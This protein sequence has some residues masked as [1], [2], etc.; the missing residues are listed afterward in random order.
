MNIARAIPVLMYHHVSPTPGLVTISPEN[1]R[2]QM[3]YLAQNGWRT[4][5]SRELEDFFAGKPLPEKS[6]MLTF[7]DGW[8]DNW[9]HAHPIL[10]EFGLKAVLFL[11]TG[12]IGDGP[13][14]ALAVTD[15][16]T[17]PSCPTR[18]PAHRVC[19]EKVRGGQADEVMLRWSE[20]EAMRAAGSFEFHSH[21]HTHTR[22]DKIEADAAPRREKL[23]ADLAVSCQALQAHLGETSAH[24]CWP[25]GYHDDD[26]KQAATEGGFRYLYTTRPDTCTP[27]TAAGNIPRIVVKDR[28]AGW[29]A[30][31][32]WLYR[33]PG[34]TRLYL[35]CQGKSGA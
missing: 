26:Y 32:L 13:P 12:W 34:L 14:R 11:I 17:A 20:V 31:R 15:D 10:R 22:W 5:G 3:A 21:T 18:F 2:A 27:S 33:Q 16:G 35:G 1:F 29:L 25:Q 7:D 19:M 23:A 9:L 30:R 8:L 4:I 28:G 6:L 24:L